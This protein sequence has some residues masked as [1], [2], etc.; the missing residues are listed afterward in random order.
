MTPQSILLSLA[1]GFIS[2][3]VFASATAGPV[4]SRMLMFVLTPFTLYLAGL[5]LGF[6]PVLIAAATATF[7]VFSLSAPMTALVYG[8]SEAVPAILLTRLALM[9][10]GDGEDRQW[11]PIG[12]VVVVAAVWS[13]LLAFVYLAGLGADVQAL[14][15]SIRPAVEEFVKTQ[16]PTLPGGKTLSEAE[17]GEMTSIIVASLPGAIALSVM[18][19]ALANLW[20]AGR[21]TLASGRLV[22]PWPDFSRL[23]LPL[24]SA[25]LLLAATLISFTSDK[26][27]LLTDGLA[28]ALRLAFA[29]LGLAVLHHVLRASPW[30]GFTL[31]AVYVALFVVS[32]HALLILALIGLAETIFHYRYAAQRQPPPQA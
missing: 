31:T 29:L 5:G 22:R 28:S 14:T 23:E 7:I 4:P 3:I 18:I 10:H 17:I 19:T 27:W 9:A 24:G 6:G 1:A 8:I 13:G 32:K 26:A 11:Y 16:M 21:V 20:L 15:K 2:A 30:R 12:R 25:I